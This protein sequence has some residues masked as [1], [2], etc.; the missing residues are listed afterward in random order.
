M[1]EFACTCGAPN[2]RGAIHGDDYQQAFIAEY[3]AHVSDYVRYKRL[4][5]NQPENAS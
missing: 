3:E 1:E 4:T 5:G 2:C